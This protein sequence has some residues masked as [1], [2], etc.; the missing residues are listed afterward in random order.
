[1]VDCLRP[2]I[3]VDDWC[4][5]P[6][7]AAVVSSLGLLNSAYQRFMRRRMP[8]RVAWGAFIA[9]LIV[10][11]IW[12][13]LDQE[14]A[15]TSPS[16]PR[17]AL[18]RGADQGD[19]IRPRAEDFASPT[20]RI[21]SYQPGSA[22]ASP[23]VYL[24]FQAPFNAK[25]GEAFDY[26]VAID[27]KQAVGRITLEVSYDPALL[28]VRTAEEI[29]YR[30]RQDAE[31]GFSAEETSDGRVA[32]VMLVRD[33][34]RPIVGSVRIAVVQFE[35]VAP[36]AAQISVSNISASDSAD[37]A[38]SLGVSDRESVVALN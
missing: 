1:V 17:T 7:V 24:R 32:V 20:V 3:L 22:A 34:S 15:K 4:L 25:I 16:V 14:V 21:P 12:L 36:G 38:L 29:D 31:G 10:G 18:A 23:A 26:I 30:N 11:M 19:S 28:R 27:A 37:T 33:G 6:F 13:S 9:L 2:S 8:T 35:A 5:K